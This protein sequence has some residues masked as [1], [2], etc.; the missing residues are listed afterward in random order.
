MRRS[1]L[2]ADSAGDGLGSA[3]SAVHAPQTEPVVI[4]RLVVPVWAAGWRAT[5]VGAGLRA[6]VRDS[7]LQ[8]PP[9][10]PDHAAA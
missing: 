5:R 3:S 1:R 6:G 4:G 7:L 10:P 8:R 9:E 2:C